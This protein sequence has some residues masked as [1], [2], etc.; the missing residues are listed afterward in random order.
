MRIFVCGGGSLHVPAPVYDDAGDFS[1]WDD[2]S[3]AARYRNLREFFEFE[4][5]ALANDGHLAAL[6]YEAGSDLGCLYVAGDA[7]EPEAVPLGDAVSVWR[8]EMVY[9]LAGDTAP[10]TARQT[11]I[12]A[13]KDALADTSILV[14]DIQNIG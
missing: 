3:N 9:F 8:A 6:A 7:I 4:M 13:F 14:R 1:G 12:D 10:D 11:A 2:E 5:T